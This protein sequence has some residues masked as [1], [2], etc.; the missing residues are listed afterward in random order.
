MESLW[1]LFMQLDMAGTTGGSGGGSIDGS[2]GDA[3]GPNEELFW[4]LSA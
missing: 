1:M 2:A 4:K 3:K